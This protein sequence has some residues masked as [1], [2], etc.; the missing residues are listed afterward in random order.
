[1]LFWQRGHS[2]YIRTILSEAGCME[3]ATP[4]AYS[5]QGW[6]V[7][8]DSIFLLAEE[9][10]KSQ[11]TKKKATSFS[12]RK[13]QKQTPQKALANTLTK[14][15]FPLTHALRPAEGEKQ[16][17]LL[18]TTLLHLNPHHRK[19]GLL[20]EA[21]APEHP[22][23]LCKAGSLLPHKMGPRSWQALCTGTHLKFMLG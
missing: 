17:W 8:P 2:C 18:P 13:E 9:E 15:K 3:T 14:G 16:Q 20:L 7:G 22:Q 1:M 12:W 6:W 23:V 19:P 4:T 11:L 10:Q 5:K 21:A